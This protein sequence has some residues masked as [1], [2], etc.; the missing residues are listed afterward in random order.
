MANCYCTSG[1][2]YSACCGPYHTGTKT[3]D[4]A[5]QLMRSRYSA[6]VL[7]NADYIFKTTAPAER[8][9]HSITD[10]LSWAKSNQWLKL[11]ILST[12]T[13]TVT[14]KA[15]YLDNNLKAQV[16]YEKSYFVQQGT[17]WYYLNGEY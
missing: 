1:L 15:Y 6:Y 3:P 14:F 12:T 5:L 16:H 9:Y 2:E 11:E 13:H 8:K 7:H 10:I 17:T 4:T